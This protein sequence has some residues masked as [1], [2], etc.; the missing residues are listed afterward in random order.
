MFRESRVTT[1]AAFFAT[2]PNWLLP[3]GWLV[4]LLG[5]V[6]GR[7]ATH[8]FVNKVTVIGFRNTTTKET[9]NKST[10]HTPEPLR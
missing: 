3:M 5:W 10:D 2:P 9:L 4:L 1:L 8:Q 7:P 6:L